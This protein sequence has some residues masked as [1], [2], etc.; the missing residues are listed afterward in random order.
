M[1]LSNFEALLKCGATF[2]W[3]GRIYRNRK[4]ECGV[5]KVARAV[6]VAVAVV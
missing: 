3:D 6:V 2:T 1:V 5:P 4:I